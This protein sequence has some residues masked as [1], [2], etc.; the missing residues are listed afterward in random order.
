MASATTKA[1]ASYQALFFGQPHPK[2][3]V[4]PE[5]SVG[6]HVVATEK[7]GIGEDCLYFLAQEIIEAL[8]DHGVKPVNGAAIPLVANGRFLGVLHVIGT[9]TEGL[10]RLMFPYSPPLLTR[11]EPGS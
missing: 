10:M 11:Q 1:E 5:M 7:P 6:S 9:T 4:G 3:G 2:A 8:I